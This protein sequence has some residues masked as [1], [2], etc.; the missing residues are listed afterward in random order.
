M[1]RLGAAF[2][3]LVVVT[4]LTTFVSAT[5]AGATVITP[6]P[7]SS[8]DTAD[9]DVTGG[10]TIDVSSGQSVRF[11]GVFS[12][13]GD[14]TITGTGTVILAGPGNTF[15]GATSVQGT[16]TLVWAAADQ[17]RLATTLT[18]DGGAADLGGFHQTV[19]ALVM[20]GGSV[21]GGKLG[22][23]S[24]VDYDGSAA[25][26]AL[27]LPSG[28]TY[29]FTAGAA[30]AALDIGQL[31]PDAA[32]AGAIVKAGPGSLTVH[33]ACFF[34]GELTVDEGSVIAPGGYGGQVTVA[35]GAS[36]VG[37]T[38]HCPPTPICS[39]AP[40]LP[41]CRWTPPPEVPVPEPLALAPA[42]TG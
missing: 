2:A 15:S 26:A 5:S 24:D 33:D 17:L 40:D 23:A 25:V 20:H 30:D 9:H 34:V 28:A 14:L 22:V 36:F 42:F 38:D 1:K 32:P 19:A 11:E 18:V 27:E 4:S 31:W 7:G 10:L 12:G 29:T 3:V 13:T 16:A 39:R 6:P 8:V 41:Y 35:P 21:A 37:D